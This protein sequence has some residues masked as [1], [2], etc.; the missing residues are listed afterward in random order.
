MSSKVTVVCN[1][2]PLMVLAKLNVLHL[3]KELY[4]RVHIPQTVYD[5][6]VIAGLRHGHKDAQVLRLFFQ[7]VA[8]NPEE[9]DSSTIPDVLRHAGLDV[10]EHDTLALALSLSPSLVLMDEYA[11]RQVARRLKLPSRGS[12]GILIEAYREGIISAEQIS[13]YFTEIVEDQD[14]WISPQLVNRLRRE[15]LGER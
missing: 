10:G 3:L 7:S 2:G 1:A 6:V 4:E 13:F 11:G 15:I 14:I 8:W 9:V 5:E 12:L